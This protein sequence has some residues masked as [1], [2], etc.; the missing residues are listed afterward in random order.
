MRG[1][2]AVSI[3]VVLL[4]QPV[5]GQQCP[6]YIEKQIKSGAMTRAEAQIFCKSTKN[7]VV[8]P[9]VKPPA[10]VSGPTMDAAPMDAPKPFPGYQGTITGLQVSTLTQAQGPLVGTAYLLLDNPEIQSRIQ[11]QED[12]V[13]NLN[14]PGNP[15]VGSDGTEPTPRGRPKGIGT[16]PNSAFN[17]GGPRAIGQAPTGTFS[18]TIGTPGASYTTGGG[19]GAAQ[20]QVQGFEAI[21]SANAQSQAPVTDGA[22]EI[23]S[24]LPTGRI[25]AVLK[26]GSRVVG[27]WSVIATKSQPIKLD[28]NQ[29]V[30]WVP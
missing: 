23:K 11:R 7:T 16:A 2:L 4:I 29:A 27:V 10:A 21:A 9:A 3:G 14:R 25:M 26:A 24:D 30:Y 6:D 8:A 5:L 12:L 22:F 17:T 13:T 15:T 18:G 1:F 20:T 19:A 28:T